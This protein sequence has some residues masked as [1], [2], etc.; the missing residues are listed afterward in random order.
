MKKSADIS[1]CQNYR[2]SLKRVWDETKPL[3]GFIGLN[4]STAD[5]IKD[6]PTILKCIEFAKSWGAGGIYMTN[7]F[8]YRATHPTTMMEQEDP[9]GPENDFYLTQLPSLTSKIVACWGNDGAYNNRSNQVKELLKGELF[10]LVM[11]K[12]GEPRHPLF[13]K[14]STELTLLT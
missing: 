5:E 2:Y 10:C 12:T 11:N 3:I 7:V 6:D 4:P 1:E 13:V 9:I 8:A 14:G